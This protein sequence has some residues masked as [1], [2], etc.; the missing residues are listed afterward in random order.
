[1]SIGFAP[2][3]R[4]RWFFPLIVFA[5]VANLSH[6]G[7]ACCGTRLD[8]T[9]SLRMATGCCAPEIAE[10]CA[11]PLLSPAVPELSVFSIAL[12]NAALIV[13]RSLQI[14]PGTAT[15]ITAARHSFLTR[16]GNLCLLH[17][18]LLI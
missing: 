5:L 6:S 7:G 9:R 8:L 17:V 3:V 14:H 12:S 1:V 16:N 11:S 10:A 4:Y 15:A 13:R 2:I 18:Q